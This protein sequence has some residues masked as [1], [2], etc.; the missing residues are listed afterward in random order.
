MEFGY[1]T[2]TELKPGDILELLSR[3][4]YLSWNNDHSLLLASA[5]TISA[6]HEP[7]LGQAVI[8]DA[9]GFRPT[10]VVGFR[11]ESNVSDASYQ[12]AYQTLVRATV[13][14]LHHDQGDAVLLFNREY[15]LLHRL[16]G[17]LILN[18]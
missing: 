17:H 4:R 10:V 7:P 6:I 18:A 15:I 9:F 14:L 3:A 5:L 12:E 2:A 1:E 13:V 8:E 16:A 11:V